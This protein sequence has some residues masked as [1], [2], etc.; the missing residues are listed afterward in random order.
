M[1][2]MY[3]KQKLGISGK[4]LVPAKEG[5]NENYGREILELHTLGVDGGYTQKDVQEV[6]RCFTGWGVSGRNGTFEFR[7]VRHDAGEKTVLGVTI[8]PGGG[9]RDGEKVLDILARHPSTARYISRKLC[10]RF[11][12][13]DPPAELVARTAKV[14][15][16]SDGDIRKVVAC[17]RHQPGVLQPRRVPGEDQVAL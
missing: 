7:A 16:A 14:F 11:V 5:P 8:P 17:D 1:I 15:A 6:A 4:N 9:I 2:D 13:D 12:S 3:V 10:Q